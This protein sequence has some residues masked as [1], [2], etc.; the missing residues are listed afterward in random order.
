MRA[1]RVSGI[2]RDKGIRTTI[3]AKDVI[4]AGNLLNRDFTAPRP[5]HT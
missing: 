2:R 3:P 4:R 1:H 5:D